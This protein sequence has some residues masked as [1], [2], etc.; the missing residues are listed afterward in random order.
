MAFAGILAASAL[1]AAMPAS[2]TYTNE[3]DRYF[4][5]EAG[6]SDVPEWLGIEID[7]EVRWRKVDAFGEALS[8]WTSGLPIGAEPAPGG[9]LLITVAGGRTE[10]RR[11]QR[12]TCW[13]AVRREKDTPDGKPDWTSSFRLGLQDQGGRAKAGGEGAEAVH[14]RMR[15]VIWPAPS[16]R[17]PNL[18]LYVHRPEE[19]ERAVS[20]AWSDAD[21]RMVGINLRWMQGS[22]S[23]EEMQP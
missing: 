3:E 4:A 11:G 1:G 12:F 21:A 9:R 15:R 18:V 19:P 2:G 5:Q 17:S 22:C 13:A 10:L 20:Y 6:R 14:L 16:D 7:G 8:Q 23:R